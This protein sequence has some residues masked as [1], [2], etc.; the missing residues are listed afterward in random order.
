MTPGPATPPTMAGW[1]LALRF[2][3]EL[4]ALGGLALAAWNLVPGPIRV[5]A[6]VIVPVAAAVV[7]AVFNVIGD[8]SRSGAAPVEVPGPARLAIE[9]AILGVGAVAFALAGWPNIGIAIAGAIAA[10]YAVS[11][12]RVLWLLQR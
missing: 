4:A 12:P 1:N 11:W 3:L 2:G 7:W 5:P 6:T 8:P 10:H 9:L